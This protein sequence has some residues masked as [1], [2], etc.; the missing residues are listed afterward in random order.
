MR[1]RSIPIPAFACLNYRGNEGPDS[2]SFDICRRFDGI[3][4]LDRVLGVTV[5]QIPPNCGQKRPVFAVLA[6]PPAPV[7]AKRRLGYTGAYV[8]VVRIERKGDSD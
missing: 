2:K 7:A 6:K 3:E 4:N 8:R 5:R 1:L